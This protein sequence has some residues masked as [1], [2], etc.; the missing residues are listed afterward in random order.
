MCVA[1]PLQ[2]VPVISPTK[3]EKTPPSGE[4][5]IEGGSRNVGGGIVFLACPHDVK[6]KSTCLELV[7]AGSR[8]TPGAVRVGVA[9]L[10]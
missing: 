3:K 9:R 8:F 5:E 10:L 6:V 7:E 4:L 2:V 1:I